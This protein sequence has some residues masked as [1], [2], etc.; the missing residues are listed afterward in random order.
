MDQ[1]EAATFRTL[2]VKTEELPQLLEGE[3]T[4]SMLAFNVRPTAF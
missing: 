4:R 2:A 3:T 1:S